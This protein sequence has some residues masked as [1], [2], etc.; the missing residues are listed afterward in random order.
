M[1][2][3]ILN[4]FGWLA[5]QIAKKYQVKIVAITGSVGKTTT[6]EA[7][8]A[9]LKQAYSAERTL[10]NV[11]TEWGITASVIEP[12]FE[13][14]FTES[15]K[16]RITLA[17]LIALKLKG[18]WKLITKQNYPAVLVLEMAADRPGDI[19]WF[20]RWFDY[21]IAV[22]TTIGDSHLEFYKSQEQLT[23]EK[24]SLAKKL[25]T[26]GLAIIN[27][28][29]KECQGLVLAGSQRK[30]TFGWDERSSY[31]AKT[32]G[33]NDYVLHSPE[34]KI[35]VKLPAGRQFVPAALIAFA[36][37]E[38]FGLTAEQIKKGLEEFKPIGGRFQIH[39]TPTWTIID[40]TYNASPESMR[41]AMLSLGDIAGGRKVAILGGMR[42]LGSATESGHRQVGEWAAK[43]TDLLIA[44]GRE[45]EL[46]AEGAILAGML[47]NNVVKIS[48]DEVSPSVD[49][50]MSQILPILEEGDTVLVKAS[51]ALHLDRLASRLVAQK[52]V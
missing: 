15:G 38:E 12:G 20:N 28:E 46:I 6:K 22:I 42:E 43:Q 37:G 26:N 29:C 34:E 35:E 25:K 19:H 27:G 44:V 14:A 11:N 23:A 40:D 13:P 3:L 51:R 30:V 1:K 33:E 9:V 41:L 49:S 5:S 17:Q 45:G 47:R 16:A 39:H 7:V 18:L 24:L 31:W 21:D 2:K 48:W 8:F 52:K 32:A 36:A 10:Q 4:L 50:A